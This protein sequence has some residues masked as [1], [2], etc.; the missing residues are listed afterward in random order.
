MEKNEWIKVWSRIKARYPKWLPTHVETEDWTMALKLYDAGDVEDAARAVRAKYTA[1]VPAL[2]WFIKF[3][4]DRK[5]DRLKIKAEAL[6]VKPED[7]Y[8]AIEAERDEN[9]RRLESVDVDLLRKAFGEVDKKYGHFLTKP[10]NGN[11]REWG[12]MWRSAVY[13]Y[14][15]GKENAD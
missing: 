3:C 5:K 15:F 11:V 9:I 10:E 1:Q 2:K 8:K 7:D 14:I 4:E 6:E 13:I 12:S